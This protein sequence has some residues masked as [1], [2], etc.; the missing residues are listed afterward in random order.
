MKFDS[1]TLF[2]ILAVTPLSVTAFTN[3]PSLNT[4][5]TAV[6][7]TTTGTALHAERNINNNVFTNICATAAMSAFLW[8]SPTMIAGQVSTHFAGNTGGLNDIIQHNGMAAEARDMASATGSRV[9][10]DAESLLRLGLPIKNKEV[11]YLRIHVLVLCVM[12]CEPIYFIC[13]ASSIF[14]SLILY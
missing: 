11:C 5:Q 8:A 10:K 6:A 3:N 7:A 12:W 9:N 4:R 13:F 1:T 2:Y 14:S